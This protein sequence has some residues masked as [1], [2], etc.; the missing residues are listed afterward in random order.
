M[1]GEGQTSPASTP[2][3]ARSLD[4]VLAYGTCDRDRERIKPQEAN[5]NALTRLCLTTT[6]DVLE[7]IVLAIRGTPPTAEPTPPVVMFITVPR[8]PAAE[9][10][11]TQGGVTGNLNPAD[12]PSTV[13]PSRRG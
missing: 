11:R 10:V 9:A 2:P 6:A 7:Q 12:R 3:T 5:V 1:V 4:I 8:S 13:C